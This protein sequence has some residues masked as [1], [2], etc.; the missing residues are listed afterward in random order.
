MPLYIC[1]TPIGNLKDIT[2]RVLDTLKSVDYILAEDTRVT[3]A[4]LFKYEIKKPVKSF[5][6][7]SKKNVISEIA[8]DLANN[9]SI[10][11]VSDAGTPCIS[12]PGYELVKLCIEKEI[13]FEVLPGANAILPALILSGFPPDRFF[14]YGFLKRNN[15]KIRKTFEEIETS[16]YPVVFFESPYR[17]VRVLT[18]LSEVLPQREIA[19][20]REISKIH[21]SVVRGSVE[22]V[23]EYFRENPPKG[24]IVIVV[25]GKTSLE[26]KE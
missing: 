18:L 4:L 16:E 25:G 8:S 7:Y 10:A 1:P 24:E 6:A 15:G 2:I 22:N 20:V 9:K 23:L 5:H 13:P 11:L 12:D 19:I 14:F 17:L 21:E 26:K 3:K